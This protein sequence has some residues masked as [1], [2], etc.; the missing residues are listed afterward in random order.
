MSVVSERRD[1]EPQLPPGLELVRRV[2]DGTLVLAAVGDVD[3]ETAPALSAAVIACIDQPGGQRCVLDL[4]EVTFLNSTGLTA[5]LEATR[6]SEARRQVLPIVVD[7]NRPV[8]RPIQ[9]TGLDD[10]LTLYHTVN[11]AL[12][13]RNPE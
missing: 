5:L 3:L 7:G 13:A 9:V 4:T 12:H 8:I 1:S 2:V 10:I 6:H 11:E